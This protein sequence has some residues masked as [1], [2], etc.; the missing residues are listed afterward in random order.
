MYPAWRGQGESA[1]TDREGDSEQSSDEGRSA[2][3]VHQFENYDLML[4]TES[5]PIE[6]GRDAMG[7]TYRALDIDLRRPVTLKVM[8]ERDLGEEP[9]RLRFCA[10]GE[11]G[12]QRQRSSTSDLQR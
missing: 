11:G 12:R 8:S 6:F 5:R 3:P 9:A 10:R 1:A 2:L 7:V 4:D